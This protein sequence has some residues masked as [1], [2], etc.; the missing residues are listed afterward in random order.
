MPMLPPRPCRGTGCRYTTIAPDGFCEAHRR[1]WQRKQDTQRGTATARGYG[2][3]HRQWR[4]AILARDPLCVACL[5]LSRVT[6]ATVADHI[7]PLKQGG[8][9]T[10]ENGQGLCAHDHNVKRAAESRGRAMRVV[11]G[12]G[13]IMVREA[14]A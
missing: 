9:W 13:L 4:T 1:A 7:T 6:P 10:L 3:Q 2:V 8:D 11:Q 12:R 5:A 14:A